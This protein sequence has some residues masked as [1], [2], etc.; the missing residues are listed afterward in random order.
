MLAAATL[1]LATGSLGLASSAVADDLGTSTAVTPVAVTP[2]ATSTI[3]TTT[4]LATPTS[5]WMRA[6]KRVIYAG[7]T[8]HVVGKIGYHSNRRRLLRQPLTLQRL[9][10]T[11]W[12]SI[13]RVSTG[14]NG[15]AV[16]TLKPSTT[17]RYRVYYAGSPAFRASSSSVSTITVSASTRA[18]RVLRT[19]AA[20]TGKWY[21]W[22]AAGPSSF[23]CSGL[24]LF[25]YRSVGVSL[26]HNANAQ[27]SYGRA[28]SRAAARPGDLVIFLSGG[29]GYHAAIY[30]G[31]GY[32]YDA[33]H[34]GTTVGRHKIYSS[35]VVFRRLV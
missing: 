31:G 23:D 3:A 20:Q 18:Q 25:A 4:T 28:V 30:A 33:P 32:M 26:P 6:D 2:T 19:A 11:V 22:G 29:Y 12:H 5:T 35:N 24:T 10:A 21:S 7:E 1:G 15:F 8:V 34:S 16:F 17:A 9:E 27:K 13:A 14:T